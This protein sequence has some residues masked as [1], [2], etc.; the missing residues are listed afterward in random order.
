MYILSILLLVVSI[1]DANLRD[2]ALVDLDHG[3][4]QTLKACSGS[5]HA[6]G[7]VAC[8]A[9]TGLVRR[10]EIPAISNEN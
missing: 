3:F 10:G 4:E 6:A 7:V 8:L 9:H 1:T 2:Q 5:V